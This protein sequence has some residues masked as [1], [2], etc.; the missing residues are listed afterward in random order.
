[1]SD[2]ISSLMPIIIVGGAVLLRYLLFGVGNKKDNNG[3]K[4]K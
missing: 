1:M 3:K 2:T 4:G